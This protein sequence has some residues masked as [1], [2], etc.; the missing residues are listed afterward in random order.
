MAKIT[1]PADQRLLLFHEDI[2]AGQVLDSL[3]VDA[4]VGAIT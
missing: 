4:A 1:Q 3:R 2:S